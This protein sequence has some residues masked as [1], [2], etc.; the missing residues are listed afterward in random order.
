MLAFPVADRVVKR[1]YGLV[2]AFGAG[3]ALTVVNTADAAIP[4][5]RHRAPAAVRGALSDAQLAAV[6]KHAGCWHGHELDTAVAVALAES[7]GRPGVHGDVHLQGGGWGPSVGLWQI[8][9]RTDQR[10]TGGLRDQD[11]NT[12]PAVNAA[13]ACQLWRARRWAPWSTWK[14]G[15]YSAYVGRARAAL[16]RKV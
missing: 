4:H 12:N 11:A 5:A 6:A 10:G 14:T 1:W 13:H 3:A 8:R 16:R 2:A 15:A 7:G 9:S